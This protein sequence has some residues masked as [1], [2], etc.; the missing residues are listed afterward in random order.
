MIPAFAK[1][2]P[3]L[4]TCCGGHRTLPR[5]IL[6]W[7][8]WVCIQPHI[9][10]HPA[11]LSSAANVRTKILDFR[12]FDSSIILHIRGGFLMPIG[13]FMENSSQQISVGIVLVGRLG[14]P[15]AFLSGR[16]ARQ[17]KGGKSRAHIR[18][19]T[20]IGSQGARALAREVV[21]SSQP[22]I[23]RPRQR[24]SIMCYKCSIVYTI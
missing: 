22:R 24:A 16:A 18:P 17:T 12:G 2:T 7:Q 9:P 1:Q 11:P 6:G 20:N 8:I 4:Q 10:R 21:W 19:H 23:C 13:N 3:A 14:I 15:V 5:S